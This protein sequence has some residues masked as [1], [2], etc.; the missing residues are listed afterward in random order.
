MV[1]VDLDYCALRIDLAIGRIQVRA[2]VKPRSI[3]SADYSRQVLSRS[4]VFLE[5]QFVNAVYTIV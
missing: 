4:C 3:K 2:K 1:A 5:V